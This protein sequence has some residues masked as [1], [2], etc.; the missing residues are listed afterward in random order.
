MDMNVNSLSKITNCDY[1]S[2][3]KFLNGDLKQIS[4]KKLIEITEEIVKYEERFNN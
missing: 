1:S 4:H 2:L 3:H